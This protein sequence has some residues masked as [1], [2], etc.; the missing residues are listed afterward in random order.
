MAEAL[1]QSDNNNIADNEVAYKPLPSNLEAE[2]ALLGALLINNSA[3]EKVSGYLFAEHFYEPVHGRIYEAI[4]KLAEKGQTAD[5]IKLK[6]YFEDDPA[7]EDVGGTSYIV[8]L[9]SSAPTVFNPEDYA[10]TIYDLALRRDLIEIGEKM[11]LT[12]YDSPIDSSASDQIELAE[13]DL[14]G[15][16]ELGA[17]RGGF[18][19]FS[20]S[21]KEALENIE[22]AKKDPDALSGVTTGLKG[23]NEKMG[24]FHKSDL[25]ILAGR[26]AMGKAQPLD[27][28]IK[29]P[30]GWTTMGEIKLGDKL[31]SIDGQT[32]VVRSIFPQGEKQIF[33][34]TFSDGRSAE[35]CDD[36]LWRVYYRSWSEPRILTTKKIAEMLIRK[37]YQ[38]RLWIEHCSGHFGHN[39]ALPVDPWLLGAL[40][41]DGNLKGGSIRFST[42]SPEILCQ[43]KTAVGENIN[44]N[45]LGRYDYRLLQ[46]ENHRRPGR[47]G[48]WPNP[49]KEALVGLGLWDKG[50]HE[51]FIPE[52]YMNAD[53]QSRLALLRGLLDT[54]GWVERW[55]T[56]RFST[57]SKQ[58]AKDFVELTRSL[59]SWC[60]VKPKVPT[61][62]YSGKKRIGKTAYVCNIHHK[63]P[64][65]FFSV[66][67]K[68]ARVGKIK[69]SKNPV[70]LSVEPSR[71]TEAQCIAVTHPS[72]LYI[73]NDY[74]VT[75]NTALATNMAFAAA[76][77]YLND[78]AAGADLDKSKG[79]V[80]GFFSLEMSADQLA[81]RILAERSGISS[82]KL[83][84]GQIR[85]TQFRDVVRAVH[86]LEEVPLF[87]DDTPA[88]NIAA[89]RTRA[90]RL[91]RLENLG[92]IVV[93]YLQLLHGTGRG[94]SGENRVQEISEITRGLKN[95]AKELNVP[96]LA[97]SQ[98]SRQVEH[99]D[100]KRPQLSDLRESGTIEQ[101]A[102]IV[103][104]VYREEYYHEKDKPT[105]EASEAFA[106]WVAKSESIYGVAEVIIGKQRHGP[107]GMIKLHFEK[108]VTRFTDLAN[109]QYLPEQ[110]D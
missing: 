102:D 85:E 53:R 72:R 86:E 76:Q 69:A 33:R 15:L 61:Y 58:L 79:A 40:I 10:Q 99:R 93:D 74:V 109:D 65:D 7:L 82:E 92:M 11:M 103:M 36:H 101:D 75:H 47:Q 31:A 56:M 5:P 52:I 9:A 45:H 100:N 63:A 27:A 19:R 2:Q 71:V 97:L 44:I 57:S 55:G 95:L 81:N 96:V 106:Q 66:P 62:T 12:A 110:N 17:S 59:G 107:T 48:V 16:A 43:M 80:V 70:I 78:Q 1:K 67:E 91:K 18:R 25:I 108:E 41:G 23:L 26:P 60:T 64:K 38:K 68:R 34:I 37:R 6:P 105:D 32:S 8:R 51:K 42:A 28:K 4:V 49:L 87:I 35:C 29:T 83:R 20:A 88:L 46:S 54:D 3:V 13:Q 24:G 30:T 94:T 90:R 104:F 21:L 50:S 89:L 22:I 84:R 14:F 73:T 77:R 98:L 39:E